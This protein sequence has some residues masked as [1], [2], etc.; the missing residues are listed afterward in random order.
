MLMAIKPAG[1]MAIVR[2]AL[3]DRPLR[4]GD[5]VGHVQTR[6]S[7]LD[8]CAA[9]GLWFAVATEGR[10]E[11]LASGEIADGGL[12]VYWPKLPRGERHGR[13]QMRVV[14]R[15]MFPSIVFIKCDP[16]PDHWGFVRS[17][18]GVRRILGCTAPL[19]IPDGAI[20]V[21]RLYEA[22]ATQKE[23]ERQHR[24]EVA[25]VARDNGKSG[26][27]WYFE[28]GEVVRIKHGPFAG[29]NAQLETAVDDR[30]RINA[31]VDVLGGK[32]KTDLS[33]FDI[34]AL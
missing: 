18:R 2:D 31:L 30:D 26:L 6:G 34:E 20:E 19:S 12:V 1:N 22:E 7:R 15:S 33:A 27:V 23:A 29:F 21:V 9:N 11:E 24:E 14:Y 5:V 25:K 4:I 8:Y 32:T 28:P 13:G 10:Q 16:A 17:A 3:A